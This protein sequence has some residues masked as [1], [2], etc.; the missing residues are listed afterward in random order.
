MD[1]YPSLTVDH[2]KRALMEKCLPEDVKDRIRFKQTMEKVWQFLDTVYV[3][4]NKFF[5]E[6]MKP[7]VNARILPENDYKGMERYLEMLQHT[8]EQAGEARML[9]VMLHVNTFRQMFEKWPH[10]KKVRW[11]PEVA[12]VLPLEQPKWF[13][14]YI[15]RR[16][17]VISMLAGLDK[18]SG[19][20]DGRRTGG[21]SGGGDPKK[22]KK[23]LQGT[24]NLAQAAALAAPPSQ[25]QRQQQQQQGQTFMYSMYLLLYFRS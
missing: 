14:K 20:K 17:P 10:S 21:S 24:V 25:P 9:E 16:Y 6:L 8:F 12:Y 1:V 4:P 22:K 5:H 15:E 18:F 7:V 2:L 13:M 23:P 11:W 3:K 19:S